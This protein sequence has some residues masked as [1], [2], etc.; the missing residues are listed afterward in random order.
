MNRIKVGCAARLRR[1]AAFV[2]VMLLFLQQLSVLAHAADSESTAWKTIDGTLNTASAGS[3]RTNTY[4]LEVSSG[5]RQGGG[6]A[7]NVLY[8]VIH[9][10][11]TSGDQRSVILSP[12]DDAVSAG[13]KAAAAIGNRDARRATVKS[14][15]GYE[16]A[17]LSEKKALGSV[18]TDQFMFTA[19]DAVSTIDKIQIFGKRNE[20]HGNWSCQGMRVYRV[21]TVYGL[22]MYGWYSDTGFIDF[23]GALIADVAMPDGGVTFRWS[24]SAGMY[25]ITPNTVN[26]KLT[27]M[28]GTGISSQLSSRVVIRIDLADVAGAGFESLAGT[29][30]TEISRTKISDLKF[31]ETAALTIRY[32][33]VYG[34]IREVTLPLVINALGQIMETL[35][36]ADTEIAEF[37]QQ[38]D[39]IAVPAVLPFF[40]NMESVNLTLGEEKAAETAHLITGTVEKRNLINTPVAGGVFTLSPSSNPGA[41]LT[42][43]GTVSYGGTLVAN[44]NSRPALQHWR[45]QDA[46]GGYFYIR[47]IADETLLLDATGHSMSNGTVIALYRQNSAGSDANQK[48]KLE[49]AGNGY[50]GLI[51]A[52]DNGKC[53][54]GASGSESVRIWDYNGSSSQIWKFT[55]V[56]PSV[57]TEQV[58]VENTAV[59]SDP[60]RSGRVNQSAT[61]GISYLCFA[62]YED[63]TVQVG[64]E[65]ATL[66]TR[67]IDGSPVKLAT[68]TSTEGVPMTADQTAAILMRDYEEDMTLIP[69]DRTERYLITMSTD[70]VPN[71]GT[72]GDLYLRF[73]Y[74]SV[75]D[76]ELESADYRVRDYV[77][78]FYGQWPGNTDEFAYNYCLRDGGTIQF[79]IPLQGVKEFTS[80]SVR[81]SGEDEWQFSGIDIAMVKRP[82]VKTGEKTYSP[83]LANWE[84]I[85][86]TGLNN[87]PNGLYSHLVYTREVETEASCFTV[88]TVYESEEERPDPSNWEPGSLVQDDG[89]T[90]TYDGES[91]EVTKKDDVPWDRLRYYMT[92]SDAHQRLG[93]TR[94]RCVYTVSVQVAGKTVNPGNDDCGSKNLFYFRLVFENGNSGCTLANQQIIGDAF[95]TGELVQFKIP[96]SQDYGEV[97]AVQ[98]IPDSQDSNS[99]IYDKLQI[100]EISVTRDSVS[101]VSP[102]WTAK[103]AT[104]ADEGWVGIDYRD[105]GEIGSNGG[106]QGRSLSELATTFLITETSYSTNLLVSIT[107]AAY[108]TGVQFSGGVGMELN[109]INAEGRIDPNPIS[110]FDVVGAMNTYGGLSGSKQ[111]KYLVNG[112]V[113]TEDVNYYVSDSRYQFLPGSTDSFIVNIKNVYQLTDMKLTVYSDTVTHWTIKDVTISQLN[114]QGIRYLNSNG[115]Y[116]YRYRKGEEPTVIATW[117]QERVTTPLGV[118][119]SVQNSSVAAI[120]FA[121]DSETIKLSEDVAKWSSTITREP[122]SK[123]DTVNLILYPSRESGAADPEDYDVVAAVKY[124]DSIT[125]QTLQVSTGKMQRG[126]DASGNTVFYAIGLG[127]ANMEAIVGVDWSGTI[128]RHATPTIPSGVLQVIRGGVLVES[129]PLSGLGNN[130]RTSVGTTAVSTQRLLLQVSEDTK[131]QAIAAN[132]N[133][134]AVA[135]YFRSDDPSAQEYRSKYIFLSDLGI[136]EVRPGQLLELEYNLGN[137]SD[138]TGINVV[139]L[140]KFSANIDCA[141][142]ADQSPDGSIITDRCMREG[143]TPASIPS[144]YAF[145]GDAQ[146]LTLTIETAEEDSTSVSG[147]NGP[148]RMS[149]CYQ[150]I[151]GQRWTRE[152]SDIRPYIVSGQRFASGSV[153]T[154]KM[155]V[156]DMTELRWIELE[157]VSVNADGSVDT[158]SMASWKVRQVS[159]FV[160]LEERGITRT[161]DQ[162]VLEGE[163]LHVGFSDIVLLGTV[164]VAQNGGDLSEPVATVSSVRSESITVDSGA[165]VFVTVRLSGSDQSFTATLDALDPVTGEVER[166]YLDP[167]HGYSDETL[168]L[169]NEQASQSLENAIFEQEKVNAQRVMDL[170]AA[171]RNTGG[172]FYSDQVRLTT[173]HNYTDAKM[174]YRIT[175]RSEENP[176]AFFTLDITVRS[177]PNELA[178]AVEAWDGMRTMGTVYV[179]KRPDAAEEKVGLLEGQ[180]LSQLLE[181]GGGVTI[182]PHIGVDETSFS[183]SILELDPATNATATAELD[184]THGYTEEQLLALMEEAR[185]TLSLSAATDAERLAARE[186][187]GAINAVAETE[188]SFELAEGEVRFTAPRNYTGSVLYY[189]I[190]VTDAQTGDTIFAVDAAV[191]P[192][193]NPLTAAIAAWRE[194]QTVGTVSV[195]DGGGSPTNEVRLAK[196]ETYAQRLESGGCLTLLPQF[197][198]SF[199]A[200]ISGLDPAIGA[201]SAADLNGAS[202]YSESE[203]SR[204]SDL[205]TEALASETSDEVISAARALL[206]AISE[207]RDS[208]GTFST[209]DSQIRFIAPRN[210]SGSTIYYRITVTS[211]DTGETMIT[212]DISV[213]SE[214][215]D[216]QSAFNDLERALAKAERA[217]GEAAADDAADDAAD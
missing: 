87:H 194:V 136:K 127:T 140:G 46:G 184:A 141:Y 81:V 31:C 163:P 143:F 77:R 86:V 78:E 165:D 60:V 181:S 146:L 94:E 106:A 61:D 18:A 1:T 215:D 93:F 211:R 100:E 166:A 102:T 192:E 130:L 12:A 159:A 180:T 70:N 62:V 156:P 182:I 45:L 63:V 105:Q 154:I 28:S 83:R 36:G 212:V 82:D 101:A 19:A 30:S 56:N 64:L 29:Y 96:T 189:R 107:T 168:N 16:T 90:Y 123:N 21:D 24:N 3:S 170:V 209:A 2:L 25:D 164:Y 88:G 32:R 89:E 142:L 66:R 188:G 79:M 22:D 47:P 177:E 126:T 152:Y 150:D 131:K 65:G 210:F 10:T 48:W 137:V 206:D 7:D 4:I 187:I 39:S 208:M 23:A 116:D 119:D 129:Y 199:R 71:A 139:S 26:A 20:Q 95:G 97:V 160:G 113:R 91:Q 214:Q 202:G 121:L 41:L 8:F 197:S 80:I 196:G 144:R 76:K 14:V 37:A 191:K 15:F 217:A 99:D 115:A 55:N 185:D 158:E 138:L 124:T 75:Q 183:A 85:A 161:V 74:I 34:C 98:V 134:L 198:G 213:L 135:L 84:E 179:R 149:L 167:T 43:N 49:D 190:L 110:G 117:S 153:D 27:M 204:M 38:G 162:Y 53:L 133:D 9:Y 33:D 145:E 120:S 148:V 169:I 125:K 6:T 174:K 176:D 58:V 186:V 203:L 205:A 114:G 103:I 42:A 147:T 122:S 151:Y 200:E 59:L 128:F 171:I 173:P 109:F 51:S 201:T 207:V 52:Q 132:E 54:D 69:I 57:G 193:E 216:V 35:K 5:T 13:F 68:A 108:E 40:E 11:T 92:F 178:A 195:L 155:L 118:Y 157:P 172:R 112:E 17:P 67:F 175:V 50:Y 72:A 73:T 44:S 111:R 104:A